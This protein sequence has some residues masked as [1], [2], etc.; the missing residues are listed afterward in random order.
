MTADAGGLPAPRT[1]HR[2]RWILGIAALAAV[3]AAGLHFAEARE[4]AHIAEHAQPWWLALAILFQAGT[5]VA[6]GQVFRGVARAGGHS[7]DVGT[8]CR[9]SLTKLFVDQAIPSA[10]VSGT[11]VLA[12]GLAERGIPRPVAAAGVV[13]DLASYYA[14][15]VL[16]L[17]AAVIITVIH[18]EASAVILLVSLLFFILATGVSVTVLR[19]SG[20]SRKGIPRRLARFR[21]LGTALDFIAQSDAQLTRSPALLVRAIACQLGVVACDTATMWVLVRSLGVPGSPSGVF[22]SFMISSLLRTVG[23]VPGG[24]GTFD[25]ASVVTLHMVGVPTAVALG[26]TLLFRGLSFWLP[27]LL[28]LWFSRRAV[29]P[30]R[31]ES[32]QVIPAW[33]SLDPAE[34]MRRLDATD[35]G[36]SSAAAADRLRRYGPN[37][38]RE[39]RSLSRARVLWNQVRSPLL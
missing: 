26:A 24:L 13:I 6:A 5:Y 4:F 9:L 1:R 20:R 35:Q 37:Q 21:P 19:L 29:S 30:A 17:A 10:G 16:S 11:V 28:G 7:L 25:A 3:I 38:L 34:L 33:W 32:R 22:A 15:Y 23:V 2:V 8:A 12:N 39:E 18:H 14:A 31:A 27:L 36:L